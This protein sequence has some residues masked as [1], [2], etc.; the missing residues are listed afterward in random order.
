[1]QTYL[2]YRNYPRDPR[3][4]RMVVRLGLESKCETRYSYMFFAGLVALVSLRGTHALCMLMPLLQRTRCISYHLEHA[5]HL[6]LP[7]SQ[8]QQS[9]CPSI[10]RVVSHCSRDHVSSAFL[11]ADSGVSM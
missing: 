10:I 5:R 2:W 9:S 3:M 7:H 6:L 4:I 1:M 8:L 11:T